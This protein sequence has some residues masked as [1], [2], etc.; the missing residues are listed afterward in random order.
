V[1]SQ[2]VNPACRA[3][4]IYFRD[5]RLFAVPRRHSSSTIQY[6]WLCGICAASMDLV[7]DAGD[8]EPTLVYRFTGRETPARQLRREA[9]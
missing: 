2:C 6:F 8:E 3:P 5:G 1:V 7:F 4:F 9:A